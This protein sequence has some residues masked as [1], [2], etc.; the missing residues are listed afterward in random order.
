M[1]TEIINQ[2]AILSPKPE[3][4]EELVAQL[5]SITRQ[6]QENE[7]ETLVYY[8]FFTVHTNEIIIVERYLNQAALERHRAAPYFQ[9]LIKRAPALLAKPLELKSG[10]QLLGGS[11]QVNRL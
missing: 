3:R 8:A 9:E 11:A 5:A 6:V 2:V 4:R 10:S 1:S 7:P